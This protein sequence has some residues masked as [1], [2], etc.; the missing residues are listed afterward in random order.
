MKEPHNLYEIL[1]V[2]RQAS[3][4][5]IKRAYYALIRQNHPDRFSAERRALQAANDQAG[6]RALDRRLEEAKR[7]T[8]DRKSVV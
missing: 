7:R 1:G 8:Q 3:T 5:Q 2:G 4:D 6:L